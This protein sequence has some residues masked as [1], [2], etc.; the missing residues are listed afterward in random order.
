MHVSQ[1]Y[2]AQF[3]ENAFKIAEKN[4]KSAL[5]I[6]EAKNTNLLVTTKVVRGAPKSAILDEDEKFKA[7]MIVIGSHEYGSI[8][9]FVLGLV[10]HSVAL[11]AKCS[12][13]IVRKQ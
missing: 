2:Y 5:E 13:E 8:K 3:D 6:L 9:R 12:V 10:S 7:N 1:Q 11:H 4:V